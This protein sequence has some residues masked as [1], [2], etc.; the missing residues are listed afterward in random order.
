MI[1][2]CLLSFFKIKTLL[3]FSMLLMIGNLA[4]FSMLFDERKAI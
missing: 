2:F 1:A 3:V 4:A